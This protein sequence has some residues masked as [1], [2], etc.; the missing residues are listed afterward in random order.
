MRLNCSSLTSANA[1]HDIDCHGSA[2]ARRAT[3]TSV[4]WW[5]SKLVMP[6]C[7]W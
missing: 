7:V 3:R 1:S 5:M 2:A 6:R 4:R